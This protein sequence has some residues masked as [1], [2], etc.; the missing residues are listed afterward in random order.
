MGTI[1]SSELI[2][3]LFIFGIIIIP[4]WKIFQKAGFSP[5]LSLLIF[6]PGI[7]ILAIFYLAFAEWPSLKK[8]QELNK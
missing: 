6:V 8:N 3:I 7:N 5:L 2:L 1:G 4:F